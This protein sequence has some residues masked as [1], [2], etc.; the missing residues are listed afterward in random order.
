MF[1]INP[2]REILASVTL[3]SGLFASVDGSAET[4]WVTSGTTGDLSAHRAPYHFDVPPGQQARNIVDIAIDGSNN[5][6]F[7]W[8]RAAARNASRQVSAG[9]TEDLDRFRELYPSTFPAGYT[10]SDVVG[11]GVDSNAPEGETTYVFF[12][13]CNYVLGTSGNLHIGLYPY[14]PAGGRTCDD[15]LAIAL[16]GDFWRRDG[17]GGEYRALVAYAWYNDGTVSAGYMPERIDRLSG[18]TAGLSSY[19]EPYHYELPSN[20]NSRMTILGIGI[21]DD[22]NHVYTYYLEE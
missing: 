11:I 5:Y 17:Q 2:T 13:D 9:T 1:T 7:A 8:Y 21:D 15:I 18:V 22:I 6:V 4:R 19:R 10:S 14:S 16:D 20:W 12:R 3:I